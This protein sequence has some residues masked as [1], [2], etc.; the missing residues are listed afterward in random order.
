MLSAHACGCCCDCRSALPSSPR[1]QRPLSLP[2]STQVVTM[3][4]GERSGVTEQLREGWTGQYA[5]A[6]SHHERSGPAAADADLE[7][8][9]R[10]RRDTLELVPNQTRAQL[11]RYGCGLLDRHAP[12][13]RRAP[14]SGVAAAATGGASA[15][16][17]VPD[18]AVGRPGCA[19]WVAPATAAAP[20]PCSPFAGASASSGAAARLQGRG[21]QQRFAGGG[22]GTAAA[23]ARGRGQPLPGA[24]FL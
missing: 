24:V 14:C 9:P 7:C 17:D 3:Q 19:C 8:R 18:A 4:A 1:L 10:P 5:T 12:A 13:L 16:P 22:R 23:A 2:V 15:W 6:A 20:C 11:T 21:E